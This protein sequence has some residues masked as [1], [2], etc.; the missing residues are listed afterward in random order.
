MHEMSLVRSLLRQVS[1]LLVEHQGESVATIHVEMG[2]L[3]AVERPLVEIAFAEQL[4]STLCRGAS[5]VID[6][7]PLSA[8]CR[9]CGLE[10]EIPQFRFLCTHCSSRQI[11]VT[12]GDE[13]RLMD[14]EI[15]CSHDPHD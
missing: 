4:N 1:D 5:L 10:F 14:V 11:R 3:S 12:G 8:V 2:P 13:F 9:D 7:V 6:E 15:N